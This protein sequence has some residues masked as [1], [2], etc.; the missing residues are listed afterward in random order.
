MLRPEATVVDGAQW[1][2]SLDEYR[3]A[4][5]RWAA[6]QQD[7]S[8]VLSVE[9]SVMKLHM[10]GDVAVLVHSIPICASEPTR[11]RRWFTS[12]RPSCSASSPTVGG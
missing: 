5:E 6:E 1:F 10:L 9:T 2:G 8:D 7:G 3:S 11:A 12:E 4:W